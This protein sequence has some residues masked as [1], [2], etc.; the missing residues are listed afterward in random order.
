VSWRQGSGQFTMRVTAPRGTA[1]D[2]SVPVTSTDDQVTVNGRVVWN[3]GPSQESGATESGGYLTLHDVR[4]G[5]T[6][7]VSVRTRS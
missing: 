5:T 3:A 1:G 7:S 2:V 6:L 4:G